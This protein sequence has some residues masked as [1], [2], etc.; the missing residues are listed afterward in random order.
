[1]TKQALEIGGV[2]VT[3]YGDPSSRCRVLQPVSEREFAMPE[4]ELEALRRLCPAQKLCLITFRVADWGDALSPWSAAAGERKFGGGGPE[5][6]RM[7][8]TGLFPELRHRW[9]AP[10]TLILA[11]YSLAG[12]FA[13]WAA[14]ETDSFSGIAAVSPSLWFPGWTEYAAERCPRTAAVYLSLGVKEEKT[15]DPVMS[16]VGA[17]LRTQNETLCVRGVNSALEWNPGGHFTEP[18]QRTARGIAWVLSALS[19]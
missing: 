10:D 15:R 13:L 2:P 11:G 7:L 8:E 9:G 14:Y 18:A 19:G 5:T 1:M 6:L 12:L 3:V 17:A 4:Q 16:A